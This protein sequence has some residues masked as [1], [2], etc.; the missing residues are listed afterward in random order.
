M[1]QH[2]IFSSNT[3]RPFLLALLWNR[4]LWRDFNGAWCLLV[5][6]FFSS[7]RRHTRFDCDWSSDVCSSD[8][9]PSRDLAARFEAYGDWRRRLSVG[10]ARFH[11]WLRQQELTDAQIDL[12][13]AQLVERLDRKSVV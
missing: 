7:R 11:E 9:I 1:A 12:K 8:L 4:W 5:V 6:F 13:V 2:M 3:Q 10:I